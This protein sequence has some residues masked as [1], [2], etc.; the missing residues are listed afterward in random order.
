[1]RESQGLSYGNSVYQI[2]FEQ[3]DTF[4]L[5]GDAYSFFLKES[6]DNCVEYV[7]HFA[8]LERFAYGSLV[9]LQCPSPDL[10]LFNGF[11]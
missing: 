2:T 7:S 9:F 5:F 11:E 10:P 4:P 1:M 3:K 8:T 6:I